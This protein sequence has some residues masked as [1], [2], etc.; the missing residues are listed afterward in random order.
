MDP[1]PEES[2]PRTSSDIS[3]TSD[4]IERLLQH[5]EVAV[6]T[7]TKMAAPAGDSEP[8]ALG[9]QEL[10]RMMREFQVQLKNTQ[11][12]LV[13]AQA[14]ME[15]ERS[16]AGTMTK[17]PLG[18]GP[19]C[20]DARMLTG[21]PTGS[22][23]ADTAFRFPFEKVEPEPERVR[24]VT[25]MTSAGVRYA[26]SAG[27]VC[28]N[29]SVVVTSTQTPVTT[30]LVDNQLRLSHEPASS[31]RIAGSGSISPDTAAKFNA[32]EVHLNMLSSAISLI[33]Q[34][35][36]R[37][38]RPRAV[39]PAKF[40][41]NRD[42][43]LK[44]FFEEFE[45]YCE[46]MYPGQMNDW[47]ILL[48]N[49]LEGS[50]ASLFFRLRKSEKR[51]AHL[52]NALLKWWDFEAQRK[53]EQATQDFML[54][55]MESGESITMFALRLEQLAGRAF[56]GVCM[57]QHD[58]LRN[59][60]LHSLPPEV[61]QRT[62]DYVIGLEGASGEMIEFDQLVRVA[63]KHYTK[64]VAN[65]AITLGSEPEVVDIS[66]VSAYVRPAGWGEV[67]R[68]A[69]RRPALPSSSSPSTI[70][71]SPRDGQKGGRSGRNNL[72][73]KR[74]G[75]R[76]GKS[77]LMC[78]FCGKT[79]HEI[80]NCYAYHGLCSY[81]RQPGHN[82]AECNQMRQQNQNYPRPPKCPYCAASHF[83]KDCLDKGVR[84]PGSECVPL[85]EG[86]VFSPQRQRVFENSGARSKSCSTCDQAH[87]EGAC[88]GRALN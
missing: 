50:Y 83:G 62:T 58:S 47:T 27:R 80:D 63:N 1:K 36:Q 84:P 43:D 4:L 53:K 65:G 61:E 37:M 57:R 42:Q 54:A 87:E 59:A 24:E 69:S 41:P 22:V 9:M 51:Y 76:S 67:V 40:G 82:R 31:S 72:S 17:R 85:N 64:L 30:S 49:H 79:N 70:Q 14:T 13:D 7:E 55:T 86:R 78:D 38:Q 66:Q 25:N 75:G 88:H 34:C 18:R 26:Q 23:L 35:L 16:D 20:P 73:P 39:A 74:L 32:V 44:D 11:R 45:R 3:V 8:S 10:T 21:L 48:G 19:V 68:R 2:V 29:T 6:G 28:E 56:P 46:I 15:S 71:E 12:D 77:P 52:K 60:F 81:C 5:P 33:A